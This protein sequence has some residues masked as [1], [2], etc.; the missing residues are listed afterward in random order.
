M[1][2]FVQLLAAN[3]IVILTQTHTSRST[4][5]AVDR[6]F[7]ETPM[8]EDNIPLTMGLLDYFSQQLEIYAEPYVC[9]SCVTRYQVD[10][11]KCHD[12]GGEVV[13]VFNIVYSY[14][15]PY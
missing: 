12:C 13:L 15:H 11:S 9:E 2:P 1:L 10:W 4:I 3:S 14:W 7:R 5:D 8:L 6:G